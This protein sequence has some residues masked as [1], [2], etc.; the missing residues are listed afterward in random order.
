MGNCSFNK[1]KDRSG[2]NDEGK[3]YILILTFK[4]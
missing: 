2:Q 1:D 3:I 4:C